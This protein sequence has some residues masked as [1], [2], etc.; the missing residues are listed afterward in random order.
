MINAQIIAQ[1]DF[2]AGQL[3]PTAAR[4]DDTDIMRAGLK[5][6]RNVRILGTR[7]LKRRP[8]RRI[9]FSTTGRADIVQ[10]T[11]GETWYMALEPGRI[12][13]RRKGA[14]TA[15]TITGMP[16]T[17]DIIGDLRFAESQNVVIIS[18]P[19]I[20]PQLFDYTPSIGLWT[21]SVFAFATDPTG[22]IRAPFHNFFLGRG[23]TVQPSARSG[24]ITL[25]FS[26]PVL[27]PGH[28]GVRFRYA[29]RQVEITAVN[30]PTSATATVIEELPPTYNVTF[31]TVSGL[32]VGDIVEGV[33]S[34]ARGVVTGI[35]GT[36]ATILVTQN[37]AGFQSSE[38]VAGPRSRMTVSSQ[39]AAA[40]AA[41]FLWE[42]ALMSDF[43]GW[44]RV[45]SKDQQR[46]IFC[47]FPQV[48][49]AVVYSATGTVNDFLVGGEP[50]DAIFEF[51][52]D[53]CTVRDVVGGADEFIFTDKGVYYVPVSEN[54][55]LVPGSI[56]FRRISDD[57]CS[58]IR[59]VLTSEGMVFVNA[60]LTRVF[61]L[62]GTGQT[63]RPYIIEDL[64]QYH[65]PL[66]KSP[67]AIT[68]SSADVTTAER[69]LYVANG[70]D[71]TLAVGRYQERRSAGSYV[72]WVPWDGAGRIEW[73]ASGGSDVIVTASYNV[74][75]QEL[76]FVEVFDE[77]LLVD[78]AQP[79][80]SST[81]TEVLEFT[82]GDPVEFAPG[83]PVEL[84]NT[85]AFNWAVGTTLSVV[86]AG[87]YR[88]DYTIEP[89]GSL[90]GQIPVQSAVGMTG[91]FSFTVEV[92]PF[93]PHAPEG[94]S[95]RQRLRRRRLK[96]V[97]ATVQRTQAIEVAGWLVPF[98]R[99][100]ENEEEPPPMRDETYRTR[101]LGRAID[102]EWSLV[103]S[104]PGSLTIL[105]LTTEVTI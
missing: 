97:A 6:A 100:G 36:T 41:T 26:Q 28:V 92:T 61:A 11:A 18:G 49:S 79:L 101:V 98:Y 59:P 10:P 71:G 33:T 103:Q 90:S 17:A 24:S 64:T 57:P 39:S 67:V 83:D 91:G 38:V 43:R 73:V 53:N 37:W 81:G 9:L 15:Q 35:A 2:S 14:L 45:V 66:I 77:G 58:T 60:S 70:Q 27:D 30:S 29:E 46:V 4:G 8:G 13:F 50:E 84:G 16:W 25:T 63:T 94:Q 44:P 32:Q 22:A 52:P 99:A 40:P 80:A 19:G 7:A 105:E 93:V 89:D 75:G 12:T 21:H 82:P 31:N 86:Q 69:Y 78:A 1:R 20:R 85:Y 96:Q 51:V 42:E 54:N 48:G 74:G 95:Q 68:A 3:D 34:S 65:S 56:S 5:R 23:I 104:L 72:G 55:P 87:W 76:R 47:D 88:G 62:V 102:P